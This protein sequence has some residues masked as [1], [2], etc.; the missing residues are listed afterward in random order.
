MKIIKCIFIFIV[1]MVGIYTIMGIIYTRDIKKFIK[2]HTG[3]AVSK[4]KKIVEEDSHGGFPAD[5]ETMIE[6]DCSKVDIEV[7]K[8]KLKKLPLSENLNLIM[9]GGKKDG[10]TYMYNLASKSGIPNI[11]DG[12]YYFFDDYGKYYKDIDD[13]NS[14][15]KLFDRHSFNFTLIMFDSN[16]KHLY[17]YEFDT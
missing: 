1:V 2:N 17:Y 12:Y 13:Y 15:K 10:R 8:V 6:Y 9:Y 16:T 7:D 3:V 4:C 5:G 14:D 11:E